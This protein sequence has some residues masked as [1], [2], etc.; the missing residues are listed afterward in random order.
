MMAALAA[1]V[2][3]VSLG[4][5]DKS[6]LTTDKQKYSYAIGVNMG[7]QMKQQGLDVDF[8]SL[9][10]G[11]KDAQGTSVALTDA[12]MQEVMMKLQKD[13]MNKASERGEKAKKEGADFLA[14]NKSKEGVKTITGD[15]PDKFI[16]Y[17]VIKEGKGPKPK[18]TDRV[19]TNYRGTLTDGTEFDSSYKGGEPVE[20]GVG[21][22]IPGWTMALTNM[23]VGSKWQVFIP[24]D[25]AYGPRGQGP[26]PANSVLIFEME[27]LA[28][29]DGNAS[30]PPAIK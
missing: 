28:I 2:F 18:A 11:A 17:K 22:V 12:E 6:E 13:M 4:A 25:L 8:E 3:A 21:E 19:S 1:G 29:K 5:A 7:K 20:F 15:S 23:P 26:I 14:A 10:K 30:T 16:Q 27:L 9:V 24:S